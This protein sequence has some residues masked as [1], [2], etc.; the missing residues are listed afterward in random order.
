MKNAEAFPEDLESFREKVG[1]FARA[2]V[3][4]HRK[5]D[6]WEL[7]FRLRSPVPLMKSFSFDARE[8]RL[9]TERI[10]LGSDFLIVRVERDDEVFRLLLRRE[11]EPGAA[12][13]DPASGLMADVAN[14]VERTRGEPLA[15]VFARRALRCIGRVAEEATSESLAAA[16]AAPTDTEV[17]V[18]ALQ[19][20]EAIGWLKELDPLLPSKVRGLGERER[21]LASEG[22]TWDAETVARHLHL[23]R[24]GVNRRRRAGALLGI[25]VGR[26]GYRYPAWQFDRG[27]TLPGLE[28][29]LQTLQQHDPWMQLIF[30]VS[31]NARLG[32]RTPL[33]ALR[34]GEREEVIVAARAFGHHGAP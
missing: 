12:G 25:D 11:P 27:G 20:P 29:V 15:S 9:G 6:A 8:L 22:G 21:L 17:V 19:Q 32:S 33:E 18:L 13:S 16:T 10:R 1:V 5:D 28:A 26:R 7:R 2:G 34:S 14:L 3:S 23:T 4:A 30:M 24:Q 31:A